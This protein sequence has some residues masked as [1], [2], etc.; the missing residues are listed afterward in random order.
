M[1]EINGQIIPSHW[2]IHKLYEEHPELL[3]DFGIIGSADL[4]GL[5]SVIVCHG[6][7]LLAMSLDSY[8]KLA[9]TVHGSTD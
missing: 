3:P 8:D 5:A 2:K 1:K 7:D 4:Y 6:G 9:A